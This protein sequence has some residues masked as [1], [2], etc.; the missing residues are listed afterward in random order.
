MLMR[1][2]LLTISTLLFVSPEP[3]SAARLKDLVDVEGLR[4]NELIGVGLVVGL[5][6]TGDLPGAAAT[7]QPLATVLRNLGTNLDPGELRARNVALVTVTAR[8]PAFSR[9]GVRFDVTVSSIGTAKS[10]AGGTLLVTALKGLNRVTY[11]VAQGP[12][13]VGG[14]EASSAQTGSSHRRNFVNVARV[15][16]GGTVEREVPQTLPEDR[17]TLLLKEPDFTTASRIQEAIDA[18][19]GEALASVR[20]PGIIE[21]KVGEKWSGRVVALVAA[22]EAVETIPDAPARVVVDE[23]T[24]TIVVGAGV[25]LGPAAITYGGLTIRI[26]ERFGVSQ[27]AMF[28]R[29]G[30]TAIIPDS[31][32][33]VEEDRGRLSVVE[34]A[35][36]LADVAKALNALQVT[37]R[38]LIAILQALRASGALRAE[39][40]AL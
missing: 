18:S 3:A 38:D 2:V 5:S 8:L 26:Q 24:G 1:R 37:P 21:V 29:R 27:P 32:I 17:L 31:T 22:L 7:Q 23:R 40:Q 39:I 35:P 30:Q 16:S 9:P 6:G 20:D 25:T 15:P 10:L 36:T 4:D 28:S 12:L 13:V 34:E 14:Y 19:L 33:Q 11:G